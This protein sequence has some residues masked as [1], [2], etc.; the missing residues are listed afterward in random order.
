VGLEVEQAV[1]MVTNPNGL[2]KQTLYQILKIHNNQKHLLKESEKIA[3]FKNVSANLKMVILTLDLPT[4]I[5]S[6]RK[7]LIK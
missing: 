4:R 5:L 3:S 7:K 6:S 2:T 1:I